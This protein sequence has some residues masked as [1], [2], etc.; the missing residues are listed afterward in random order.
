M[1]TYTYTCMPSSFCQSLGHCACMHASMHAYISAHCRRHP[2]TLVCMSARMDTYKQTNIYI[3]IYIYIYTHT[4]T[5]TYIHVQIPASC[6]K[7]SPCGLSR[8]NSPCKGVIMSVCKGVIMSVCKGVIM[9]V[10]RFTCLPE[11]I[12]EALMNACT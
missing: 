4:H 6:S 5:H 9:S 7:P 1:R 8:W 3:Y 12:V 2:I 10:C 11:S